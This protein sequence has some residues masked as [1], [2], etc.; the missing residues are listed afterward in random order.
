[1]SDRPITDPDVLVKPYWQEGIVAR[2]V[3]SRPLPARVDVLIVGAGY[4]GL[5]AARETS[6]A[7]ASTLVLEA[8]A[9]GAG[10]SGRNGGQVAYSIKP[11]FTALKALHGENRAYAICREGREAVTYLRRLAAEPGMDFDWRDQGCFFGAHTQRHFQAMAR[12]AEN[13]P[14]GLEQRISV[15]PKAEQAEEIASDFYHGGCV[16][17][18]DASV[19]PMRLLLGLLRRAQDGGADV[20]EHCPVEAVQ[21]SGDGFEI[22]TP[23]G[24]IQARKVLIATNG[25]SGPAFPWLR[26]RVIPI[27]SYQIATEA[28]GIEAVRALIP[29]GRN[30]VDSRRVVV[31]YRPSPDGQRIIFGGRAALAEKDPLACVP[32]LH[33][34]LVRIFPQLHAAKVA[35]AWVGWVAYTFDSLPHLGRHEGIYYCMGYCGQG[36]PLAPYFGTRVGQQMVGVA[37]GRTALDGLP[38]PSRPYYFGVPWF[39]AP[40][41]F[42]Y[43]TL[44]SVGM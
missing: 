10:C 7:G 29:K 44:D 38:F 25:Y 19:D 41:V 20:V 9:V 3:P 17:H 36:V 33:A 21:P 16:Y 26:R 15:V 8:G 37:Q 23:R 28:L 13:Q 34:M 11:S 42:A 27:G 1:M 24:K 22:L 5:S 35:H 4:T 31:Y 40:S 32:R 2:D 43:R 39:L 12:D 6:T 18:D 14:P 30:I